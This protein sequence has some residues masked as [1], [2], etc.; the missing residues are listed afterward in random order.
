MTNEIKVAITN[1]V[2]LVY[3]HT[4]EPYHACVSGESVEFSVP[5]DL[6]YVKK[7]TRIVR[8]RKDDQ[9]TYELYINDRTNPFLTVYGG[10]PIGFVAD[11]FIRALEH[12]YN[13]Y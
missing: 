6:G 2:Y 13:W 8:I 1:A 11:I 5:T 12:Y 4:T 10:W 7:F 9:L 3:A